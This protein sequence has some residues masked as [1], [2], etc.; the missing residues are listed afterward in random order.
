[1][2]MRLAKWVSRPIIFLHVAPS[3]RIW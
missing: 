2:R 3:R 1:M